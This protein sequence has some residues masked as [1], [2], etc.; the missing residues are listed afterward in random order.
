[1]N[2][3]SAQLKIKLYRRNYF[4]RL[5][6]DPIRFSLPAF[7]RINGRIDERRLALQNLLHFDAAFLGDL[8][9]KY[10]EAMDS[11]TLRQGWIRWRRTISKPA[12]EFVR[13]LADRSAEHALQVIEPAIQPI[14]IV[15]LR[16]Y[17]LR[18]LDRR[19]TNSCRRSGSRERDRS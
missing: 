14:G 8:H 15:I 9:L 4:N 17:F 6:F 3:R 11:R 16:W 5:S 2:A 18:R 12:Q 19:A 1:K 7:H 10:N 13:I